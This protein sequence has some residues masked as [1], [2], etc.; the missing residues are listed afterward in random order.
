MSV[1]NA[2]VKPGRYAYVH[3]LCRCPACTRANAD[4]QTALGALLADR[5]RDE[6][7][8][9]T[10]GGYSNRGCRCA[11]CGRA[12]QLK[13]ARYQARRKN[14]AGQPLSALE[15]AALAELGRETGIRR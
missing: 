2:P 8:H 15:A 1:H 6:V 4:Y 9:G 5:P 7:P 14:A 3:Y 10:V 12:N 13:C 11:E